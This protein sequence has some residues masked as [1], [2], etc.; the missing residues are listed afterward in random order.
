MVTQPIFYGAIWW[1]IKI[2]TT[3]FLMWNN[4][5]S[6][7]SLLGE[8]LEKAKVDQILLQFT[9]IKNEHYINSNTLEYNDTYKNKQWKHMCILH[10]PKY[11]TINQAKAQII[12]QQ[13][14]QN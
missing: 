8:V 10:S 1:C 9:Y 2:C 13:T 4:I 12:N 7:R 3:I 6:L 14:W 11:P 5:T